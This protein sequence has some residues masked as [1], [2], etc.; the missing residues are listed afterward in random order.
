MREKIVFCNNPLYKMSDEEIERI[1]ITNKKE[2]EEIINGWNEYVENFRQTLSN[3]RFESQEEV[4]KS[5]MDFTK[6]VFECGVKV[7]IKLMDIHRVFQNINYLNDDFSYKIK[8]I[9]DKAFV[10]LDDL[11][12]DLGI[13]DPTEHYDLGKAKY[14]IPKELM[15]IKKY[16]Y[17]K[18]ETDNILNGINNIN[19]LKKYM[20]EHIGKKVLIHEMR[21]RNKILTKEGILDELY[22]NIFTIKTDDKKISYTYIEILNKLIILEI[23][24]EL[25]NE[26]IDDTKAVD[27]TRITE[28]ILRELKYFDFPVT[29][30]EL[31]MR[32]NELGQY[33]TIDGQTI[34]CQKLSVI[35][36]T[37]VLKNI[38]FKTIE[39]KICY[40]STRRIESSKER[41]VSSNSGKN[42]KLSTIEILLRKGTDDICVFKQR[43]NE[44]ICEWEKETKEINDDKKYN[45]DKYIEETQ[46]L[47]ASNLRDLMESKEKNENIL[48]EEIE[49]LK[50]ECENYDKEIMTLGI[51][52]FL[53]RK[54][55]K[56]KIEL[57]HK[58]INEM[59]EKINYNNKENEG[60]KEELQEK[61]NIIKD[62]NI[63]TIDNKYL[64]PSKIEDVIGL[65]E[66]RLDKIKELHNKCID[67]LIPSQISRRSL[68]VEGPRRKDNKKIAEITVKELEYF[69]SP[70]TITELL[71]RSNKLA[72]YVTVDGKPISN[73]KLS[74]ILHDLVKENIVFKTVKGK[75]WYYSTRRKAINCNDLIDY[76]INT[77]FA[78]DRRIVL[79]ELIKCEKISLLHIDEFI[80][81]I[82]IS[83][84]RVLQ[85]LESLSNDKS[86]MI[87]EKENDIFYS[88]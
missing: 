71:M 32:F 62:D 37:L 48:N 9:I 75:T 41:N 63:N 28:I 26:H 83:K 73:Q 27:E 69:D 66:K 64:Y 46:N 60:K 4:S 10:F 51:F 72:Q 1:I 43:L 84:L 24:N 7:N 54:K 49:R 77:R 74:A 15:R 23:N 3:A 12:F 36:D 55:L 86:I 52:G 6:S 76:S 22:Q 8:E 82:K 31:F 61:F 21:N 35:L 17:T 68:E 2:I 25:Q 56:E 70:L 5:I 42:D 81:T 67:S 34:T 58:D 20:E 29:V 40:Y 50:K 39:E 11:D 38:V 19:E 87:I 65:Y 85:I 79:E 30:T 59:Q 13:T 53:K 78:K 57:L 47:L 33:A 44:Y 80:E 16:W 14:N 45:I 88:I 18:C